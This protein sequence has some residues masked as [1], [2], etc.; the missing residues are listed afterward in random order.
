MYLILFIWLSK[1]SQESCWSRRLVK[2]QSHRITTVAILLKLLCYHLSYFCF[3]LNYEALL[4]ALLMRKDARLLGVKSPQREA[5]GDYSKIFL[6]QVFLLHQSFLRMK[7]REG[8]DDNFEKLTVFFN[9]SLSLP[10]ISDFEKDQ[11][12]SKY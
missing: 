1:N 8:S 9:S 12:K 2:F 10:S 4:L 5:S 3:F 11:I 6:S 7:W